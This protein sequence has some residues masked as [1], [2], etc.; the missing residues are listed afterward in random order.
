MGILSFL[1]LPSSGGLEYLSPTP[2]KVEQDQM[3]AKV[4]SSRELAIND[5]SFNRRQLTFVREYLKDRNVTQA[6]IRAGYSKKGAHVAGYRL[7]RDDRI[8]R[9]IRDLELDMMRQAVIDE[10]WVL[11][12]LK[13]NCVRAIE[14]EEFAVVNR[15]L[16]LIGKQIGMFVD[17]ANVNLLIDQIETIEVRIVDPKEIDDVDYS[18]DEKRRD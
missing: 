8:I 11:K 17:R 13:E 6:A 16:E 10:A 7:L 12:H 9:V 14:A 1:S 5:I 18:I 4:S 15:S 3:D 2:V